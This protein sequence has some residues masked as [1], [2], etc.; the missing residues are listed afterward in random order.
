MCYCAEEFI[1]DENGKAPNPNH[2]EENYEYY[3]KGN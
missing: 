1:W 2:D 3:F